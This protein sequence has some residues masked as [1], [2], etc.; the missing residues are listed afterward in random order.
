VA[1]RNRTAFLCPAPAAN[2]GQEATHCDPIP[3]Q[4]PLMVRLGRCFQR[5]VGPRL[6]GGPPG[7]L[8][9]ALHQPAAHPRERMLLI[10]L[11]GHDERWLAPPLLLGEPKAAATPQA[12]PAMPALGYRQATRPVERF[13]PSDH[14]L[15]REKKPASNVMLSVPAKTGRPEFC[16]SKAPS[17]PAGFHRE[18]RNGRRCSVYTAPCGGDRFLGPFA[19]GTPSLRKNSSR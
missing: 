13:W 15:G 19:K 9:S 10:D 14:W 4:C 5:S 1:P 16:L 3:P 7:P 6:R 11:A 18:V 12:S 17:G 8:Q 2:C